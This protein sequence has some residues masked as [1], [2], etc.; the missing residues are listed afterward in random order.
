MQIKG[1]DFVV[2]ESFQRRVHTLAK[3]LEIVV[4]DAW[5]TP[6]QSLVVQKYKM[7]S[8]ITESE[9]K[10]HLYERNVQLADPK[11]HVLQLFLELLAT[12]CPP[13]IRVCVLEHT[14]EQENIRYIPDHELLALKDELK[15]RENVKR[16]KTEL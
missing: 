1:Y 3:K 4:N 13:G 16:P 15:T 9:Y 11:G 2:L 12:S 5:A 7:N 10:L 14:F 8:S 6:R